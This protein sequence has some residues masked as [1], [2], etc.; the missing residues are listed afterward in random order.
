MLK[1]IIRPIA[2]IQSDFHQK[3]G[4]PR[5]PRIVPNIIAEV[6]LVPPFSNPDAVRGLE[7]FSHIWLL[8]GFSEND[9]DMESSIP[10]WKPIVRPP[11]LGGKIKKGVFA[12]RSPYRPNSIGMSAVELKEVRTGNNSVSLLVSGADLLDGTPIYDIKPYIPYADC[13]ERA[14]GGFTTNVEME[15]MLL[16][17][18]VPENLAK[19]INPEK[20]SA[21]KE[22]LALD[23]RD[24]Y[25]KKK[26]HICKMAFADWD[27]FFIVENGKVEVKD[28]V[29]IR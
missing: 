7:E 10:D 16:E 19:K 3:Y 18:I 28:I 14:S 11:M 29:S 25:D 21:L 17:V 13:I 4:I 9:I 6:I 20:L 8:W 22:I 27:V 1:K 15:S 12:T 5:Q 24:A 23:P 26:N 2:Y